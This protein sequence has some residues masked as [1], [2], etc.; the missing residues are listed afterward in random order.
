MSWE[1]MVKR[2]GKNIPSKKPSD[3]ADVMRAKFKNLKAA[4][5]QSGLTDELEQ[6][7]VI[8]QELILEHDSLFGK[9]SLA[10]ERPY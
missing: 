5:R 3:W 4:L 8:E 2:Q 1:N 10:G 6:L 7:E 9:W